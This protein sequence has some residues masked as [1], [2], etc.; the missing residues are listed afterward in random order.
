MWA[1]WKVELQTITFSYHLFNFFSSPGLAV[2]HAFS[3]PKPSSQRGASAW[4]TGTTMAL[5]K[6]TVD[7][8]L[9]AGGCLLSRRMF[10]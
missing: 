10:D 2:N 5:A 9:M 4:E 6:L 1:C 8:A 3:T 7:F